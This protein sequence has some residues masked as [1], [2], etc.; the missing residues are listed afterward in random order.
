MPQ[1]IVKL[2]IPSLW[3]RSL[4]LSL[5]LALVGAFSAYSQVPLGKV[6]D[7]SW[8][9]QSALKWGF[10]TVT[11]SEG[12]LDGVTESGQF[13]G[14]VIC[15]S[16]G[17]NYHAFK[18]GRNLA[19]IAEGWFLYANIRDA[20]LS[21]WGKT[22]RILGTYMLRRNAYEMAYRW[23]RY[24]NPFDYLP[25]HNRKAIVYFG[26]RDGHFTDLYVG[27]GNVTGPLVDLSFAII[28]TYLL[29]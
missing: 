14:H 22:R 11:C 19:S 10:V 26:W 7:T 9:E 25:E 2:Y 21:G 13:G 28:G 17:D 29:K 8:I 4:A 23:N 18:T 6:I 1:G 12:F 3:A 20:D 15:S 5:F 16:D 24:G 27:T